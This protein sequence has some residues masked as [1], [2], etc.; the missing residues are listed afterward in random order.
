[1]LVVVST[2]GCIGCVLKKKG[3]FEGRKKEAGGR[4]GAS[5]RA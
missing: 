4:E 3:I 2:L 5:G 1:M